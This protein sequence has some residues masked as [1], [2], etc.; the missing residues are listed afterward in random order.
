MGSTI[1]A[2]KS[3]ATKSGCVSV[4]EWRARRSAGLLWCYHCREWQ[5]GENF[6]IDKSRKSGKASLCMPCN[7]ARSIRSVYQVS[8]QEVSRL[9]SVSAHCPICERPDQIMHMDHN[10]ATGAVRGFLCSRCNVGLGLFCDDL[11][12][13]DRAIKYLEAHRGGKL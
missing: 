6:T 10:H 2:E 12:L 7:S 1:G 3:A 13:L 5:D 9:Q 4:D 11:D 8:R